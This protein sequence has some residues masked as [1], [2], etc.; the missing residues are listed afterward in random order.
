MLVADKSGFPA[1]APGNP[2]E[3][4]GHP[5]PA[6]VAIADFN[7][8]GKPDLVVANANSPGGSIDVYL[9]NGDGTFG[10]A[11]VIVASAK[12]PISV[13]TADL[14]GDGLSDFVVANNDTSNPAVSVYLNS[15]H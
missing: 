3:Y 15:S 6:S 5:T 2:P 4:A 13:R 11:I 9:G 1:A 7:R 12:T 10:N 8:D 14:N